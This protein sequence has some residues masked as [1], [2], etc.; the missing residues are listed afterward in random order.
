MARWLSVAAARTTSAYRPS[1][2]ELRLD[3]NPA[4]EFASDGYDA[5]AVMEKLP[6]LPNL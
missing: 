4:I 3:N 5:G 2:F 6:P 1:D